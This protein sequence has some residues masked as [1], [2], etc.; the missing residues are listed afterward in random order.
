MLMMSRLISPRRTR[1]SWWAIAL[2]RQFGTYVWPRLERRKNLAHES[3]EIAAQQS[4]KDAR[5]RGFRHNRHL[6]SG[7]RLDRNSMISLPKVVQQDLEILG[8]HF[9]GTNGL[10]NLSAISVQEFHKQLQGALIPAHGVIGKL[11]EHDVQPRGTTGPTV[12]GH[13]DLRVH[14][15]SQA[16]ADTLPAFAMPRRIAALARPK[17]SGFWRAAIA[18]VVIRWAAGFA[19]RHRFASRS[20]RRRPRQAAAPVLYRPSFEQMGSGQKRTGA[21]RSRR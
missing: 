1:S 18:D 5:L 17:L 14:Q 12:L 16:H 10:L 21:P 9:L 3:G 8:G 13:R 4:A 19:S 20:A 2:R 7:Y 11:T 6:P 15:L